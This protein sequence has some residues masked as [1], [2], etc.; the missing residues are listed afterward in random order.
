MIP[1]LQSTF[2]QMTN[3]DRGVL[4]DSQEGMVVMVA[5]VGCVLYQTASRWSMEVEK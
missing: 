1:D 2:L 3:D 4:Y 5:L